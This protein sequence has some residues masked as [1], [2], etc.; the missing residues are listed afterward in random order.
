MIKIFT[1]EQGMRDWYVYH[2]KG[3]KG[4]V[5]CP[6]KGIRSSSVTQDIGDY[7]NIKLHIYTEAINPVISAVSPVTME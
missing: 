4:Q 3:T 1:G 2:L 5:P 7:L 6:T